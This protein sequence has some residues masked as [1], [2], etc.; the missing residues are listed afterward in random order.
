[1]SPAPCRVGGQAGVVGESDA[2]GG[3]SMGMLL[4]AGGGQG[5]ERLGARLLKGP[6]PAA[7]RLALAGTLSNCS[8]ARPAS[9]PLGEFALGATFAHRDLASSCSSWLVTIQWRSFTIHDVHR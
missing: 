2:G 6:L 4:A 9:R 8:S 7:N 5:R 3:S 1:M